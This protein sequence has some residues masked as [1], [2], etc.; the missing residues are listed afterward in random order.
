MWVFNWFVSLF[1]ERPV[2]V[3]YETLTNAALSREY[4]DLF[5]E[6]DS[7]DLDTD[8]YENFRAQLERVCNELERR[9]KLDSRGILID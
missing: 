3:E 6:M 2:A 9:G 4:L 5:D 8:A 7:T 1:E